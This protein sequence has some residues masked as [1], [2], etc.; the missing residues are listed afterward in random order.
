MLSIAH[1]HLFMSESHFLFIKVH[2]ALFA[3]PMPDK[4]L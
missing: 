1:D 3:L 2:D 4:V